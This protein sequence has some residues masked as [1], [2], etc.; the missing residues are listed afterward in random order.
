MALGGLYAVFRGK[1]SRA[2]VDSDGQLL[3]VFP[4]LTVVRHLA[5]KHCIV[6]LGG[7]FY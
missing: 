4:G 3:P 1:F 2:V 7:C 5:R 6:M